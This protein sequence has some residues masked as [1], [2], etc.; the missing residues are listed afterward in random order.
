M[1]IYREWAPK[2]RSRLI[3]ANCSESSAIFNKWNRRSMLHRRP[4]T[5]ATT[6]RSAP[7]RLSGADAI[8]AAGQSRLFI[9]WPEAIRMRDMLLLA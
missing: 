7:S 2:L 9:A 6:D 8:P 1:A 3:G 4:T 5:G